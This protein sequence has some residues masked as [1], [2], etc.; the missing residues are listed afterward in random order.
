MKQ[1]INNRDTQC[2]LILKHLRSGKTLSQKQ[3]LKLYGVHRLASRMFDLKEL[4]LK[5]HK[6]TDVHGFAHYY[7]EKK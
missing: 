4:G 1:P 6:K 7:I 3:A 2:R 5:Y